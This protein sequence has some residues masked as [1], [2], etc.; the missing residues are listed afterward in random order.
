M[1][2]WSNEPH[3]M[4][5]SFAIR[6]ENFEFASTQNSIH[7]FEFVNW[8]LAIY[9]HI[10]DSFSKLYA[11]FSFIFFFFSHH[12][13]AVACKIVSC[14]S[15]KIRRKFFFY[16]NVKLWSSNAMVKMPFSK[17]EKAIEFSSCAATHFE[18]QKPIL[19][20]Y[21]KYE[22]MVKTRRR[23]YHKSFGT[24]DIWCSKNC[25]LIFGVVWKY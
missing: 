4:W 10:F 20:F 21:V 1:Q 23:I 5:I 9:S 8:F 14:P 2:D 16:S 24:S 12:A 22:Y 19:V 15:N 17:I 13:L 6:W 7:S 11:V 25:L 18:L 3:R